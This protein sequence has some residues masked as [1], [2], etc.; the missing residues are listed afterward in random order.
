M[1]TKITRV[2]EL[3]IIEYL[4]EEQEALY[5]P[6]LTERQLEKRKQLEFKRRDAYAEIRRQYGRVLKG[7]LIPED[8]PLSLEFDK[9]RNGNSLNSL[10][11]GL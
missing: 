3:V 4:S 5:K 7:E 9:Q 11:L 8:D 2:G 6:G 1:K 10:Y